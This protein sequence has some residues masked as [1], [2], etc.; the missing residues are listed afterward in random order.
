MLELDYET[1]DKITVLNLKEIYRCLNED[2]KQLLS[3]DSL[4]DYQL[5][6]LDY[7][8]KLIKNLKVVLEYFGES[9]EE[10]ASVSDQSDW[11]AG[12][13]VEA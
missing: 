1:A 7:N 2:N 9:D 13:G 4:K 12:H 10:T 5:R 11:S 6:D 8:L 3:L